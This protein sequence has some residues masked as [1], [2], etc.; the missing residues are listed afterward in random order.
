ML[1]AVMSELRGVGPHFCTFWRFA[2]LCTLSSFGISTPAFADDARPNDEEPRAASGEGTSAK[3][4]FDEALAHYREGHYRAAIAELKAALTFDPTSKDLVYNLALVYEK[5]G[6]L[7]QAIAALER[8]AE[9]ETDPKELARA[10]LARTRMLGAREELSGP[11]V[12]PPR[13][14]IPP[15][16]MPINERGANPWLVASTAVAAAAGVVG[17][18]FGVRALVQAPG[19]TASTNASTS[20]DDLR[21][22][23]ARAETSARIAD[24]SFAVGVL[25]G[26]I[27]GFLWS[28]EQP[29][30]APAAGAQRAPIGL[31]WRAAF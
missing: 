7:D 21:D 15:L 3:H 2:A 24:V 10:R 18:V 31:H 22:Q 27:A 14:P 1:R 26:A 23:Q 5:L 30:I 19:E 28:Q 8:Y 9:L 13:M 4:H 20:I 17:V 12:L 25:S 16:S 29:K 6:E 11:V